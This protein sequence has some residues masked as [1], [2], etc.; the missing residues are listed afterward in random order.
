MG[1]LAALVCA[2]LAAVVAHAQGEAPAPVAVLVAEVRSRPILEFEFAQG[3]VRSTKR[4]YLTFQQTGR[5]DF[6]D[7]DRNG[8]PLREG[9]A[10]AQGQVL[11]TLGNE[12]LDASV[13]SARA[14]LDRARASLRA[15]EDEYVRATNLKAGDAISDRDFERAQA[16][17]DQAQASH[18][19]AEAGL[20]RA[21]AGKTESTLVAPFDGVVAFINIREGQ[22]IGPGSFN[23]ASEGTAARTAPIVVIDPESFEIVVEVPLHVGGRVAVGQPAFLLDQEAM[24]ELQSRGIERLAEYLR[25]LVAGRVAAVSPAINPDDRSVRARV[26]VDDP[27]HE[28]IDGDFVTVWLQVGRKSD[29]TVVPLNAI[30]KRDGR[31]WVF[32]VDAD[33]RAR[34][35]EVETGLIG[36]AGIEITRGVTLRER[37]VTKGKTRLKDGA[38][39]AVAAAPENTPER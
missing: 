3:I 35:R 14:Q 37:V 32:V 5:V 27:A 10:V 7:T 25:H 23:S 34:R 28:L 36:L 6:I 39:V 4:E 9:A 19:A 26:V 11:A 22:Y 29:A 2:P 21:L 16:N 15:A 8:N 33:D 31:E 1:R 38:H 20:R 30:L 12:A 18:D 13:E 17:R 24:A